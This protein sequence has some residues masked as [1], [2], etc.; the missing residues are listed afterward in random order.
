[1]VN[2]FEL[3]LQ[4]KTEW[5]YKLPGKSDGSY[6]NTLFNSSQ[7]IKKVTSKTYM[8]LFPSSTSHPPIH[9]SFQHGKA[10][11]KT[12]GIL[13]W[14]HGIHHPV[15]HCQITV[16]KVPT[17]VGEQVGW[18]GQGGPCQW[19][20]FWRMRLEFAKLERSWERHSDSENRKN[21]TREPRT[22]CWIQHIQVNWYG[23]PLRM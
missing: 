7:R 11:C 17:E 22:L 8:V 14:L 13:K 10:L 9:A 6:T 12:L 4:P 20:D 3:W 5:H 18:G 21:K 2:S 19:A 23:Y 15:H 16:R 1:M